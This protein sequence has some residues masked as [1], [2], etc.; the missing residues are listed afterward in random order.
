VAED[1]E[2]GRAAVAEIQRGLTAELETGGCE[3]NLARALR[4]AADRVQGRRVVA[5][6][7]VSDGQITSRD[8]SGKMNA[9]RAAV[10][11]VAKR[12]IPI[13]AVGV[14]DPELRQNVRLTQLQGPVKVRKG[15][16]IELTAYLANSNCGGQVVE[17]RLFY[18]PAGVQDWQ[19]TG[20][21]SQ[22]KLAGE[23]GLRRLEEQKEVLRHEAG[24]LGKFEYKVEVKPLE[25]ESDTEDNSATAKVEVSDERVKVLLVSGDGGWEFQYLRNLLLRS[26]ERYAV[27]SWQQNAET[28]FNQEASSGMQLTQLPRESKELFTYE[29][30]ILYDPAYTEGGF[31]GEFV[32]VLEDFVSNHHGAVCYIA[33]NKYTELNL[34]HIDPRGRPGPFDKLAAMLPV[35][36]DR[37]T[38]NI[39]ARILSGRPSAWPVLPTAVGLDHPVLRLGRDDP[40][41][42]H[43]WQS[44]PGVYWSYPVIKLKPLASAL[45]VSSDPE[46]R[47]VGAGDEPAPMVAMQYYGKGRV[48]Y[49]GTDESWR[50]RYLEDGEYH[51][52]F[53]FNAVDWLASGR[54]QKSRVIITTGADRFSV[55]EKMRIRVEAY[56]KDYRPLEDETFVVE[57][58]PATGEPVEIELRRD[59]KRKTKVSGQYEGEIPL[60]AVG[61]FELTAKRNDPDYKDLVAGKTITVILPEE[62]RRHPEADPTTLQ[63]MAPGEN[64]MLIHEADRLPGAMPKGKLPPLFNEVPRDLWDVPLAIVMVVT[65][66]GGEWILRKRYNMA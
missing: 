3:T 48:L 2:Q 66:L 47:I 39:A 61:R 7:I 38:I 33:G 41:N 43:I 16:D 10:S 17:L 34:T 6:V 14:G 62:E 24:Q 45:A 25:R 64:F 15:S 35:V 37:Q 26:P 23:P 56:D 50:W 57:M 53:W 46:R 36:L 52:R 32:N 18:R 63:T 22:V 59:A 19:D 5:I 54:L 9:L 60:T 11:D 55:G 27:S 31:D 20:V 29:A 44:L 30:V 1:D 13:Y 28:D 21:A 8:E 58:V 4:Q 49:L 12:H 65:L 40:E 51:K 42:L